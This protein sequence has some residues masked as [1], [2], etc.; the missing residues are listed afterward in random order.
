MTLNLPPATREAPRIDVYNE[1]DPRLTNFFTMLR[2]HPK[3]C[4][5]A[6]TLSPYSEKEF[7]KCRDRTTYAQLPRTV[8]GNVERARR[9]FVMMQ[10]SFAGQ[11]DSFSKTKDRTRRG[12]A[13]VVS[14]YLST[15]HDALP[16]IC[17]RVLEWQIEDRDCVEC[18]K[19]HDAEDTHFYWDPTYHP[20]CRA[21][22]AVYEYEMSEA[23]HIRILNHIV[24][25]K[26]TVCISH[27]RHS[28]YDEK[29]K[30]WNRHE[31]EIANHASGGKQKRRMIECLYTNY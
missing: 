6:F 9:M 18:F 20:D 16:D 4:Q 12:I 1:I 25:A 29:L 19:Y 15:I 24:Q 11:Q 30:S 26:G 3:K 31:I 2:D 27:Y 22:G 21:P 23:D 8:A 28:L 5:V 14:G 7:R 10:L 17:E 13:D